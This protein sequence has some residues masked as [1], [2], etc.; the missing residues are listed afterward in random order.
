MSKVSHKRLI[1]VECTNSLKELQKL[2]STLFAK[3]ESRRKAKVNF[4]LNFKESKGHGYI[5]FAPNCIDVANVLLGL[6]PNG[7]KRVIIKEDPDWTPPTQSDI[8]AVKAQM[9]STTN[10][11]EIADLEEKLEIMQIRPTTTIQQPPLFSIPGL[12]FQSGWA[13]DSPNNLYTIKN[14]TWA[15]SQKQKDAICKGVK[16]TYSRYVSNSSTLVS[17]QVY[18]PKS[19]KKIY[20]KES[21]PHVNMDRNGKVYINFDPNTDDAAIALLMSPAINL[22]NPSTKAN[23][24][25]LI[26]YPKA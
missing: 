16:L 7:S 22:K 3:I 26:W 24:R 19:K 4:I 5:W 20:V 2:L 15:R 21:Y 18:D 14:I 9:D 12:E 25:I 6:N 8:D 11:G 1:Y 13:Y 10:W 17:H 23:E